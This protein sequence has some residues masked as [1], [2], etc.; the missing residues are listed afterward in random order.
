[1]S[2]KV[3]LDTNIVLDL[4]DDKRA[5][6]SDAKAVLTKLINDGSTIVISEDMLSTIYYI[7]KEKRA[8]LDFFEVVLKEW[9]V[10]PFGLDVIDS[11]IKLCKKENNIDFEDALQCLC[12]LKN[13]CTAIYT[14]DKSFVDCGIEV[15]GYR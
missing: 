15:I 8:V 7:V 9:S 10:V 11:A 2:K 13:G 6:H 1:M 4:L 3:F 5:R 12:A 14:S